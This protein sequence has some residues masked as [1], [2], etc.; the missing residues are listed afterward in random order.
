[1]RNDLAD[2]I[3]GALKPILIFPGLFSGQNIYKG[4]REVVKAIGNLEV[5]VER[6]GIELGQNEDPLQARIDAIADGYIY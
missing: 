5:P 2:C 4:I 1:V 6:S 3:R